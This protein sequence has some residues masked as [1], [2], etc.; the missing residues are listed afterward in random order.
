MGRISAEGR[1]EVMPRREKHDGAAGCARMARLLAGDAQPAWQFDV[2]GEAAMMDSSAA[3]LA[4][5]ALICEKPVEGLK[6]KLVILEF[7]Y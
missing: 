5:E 2:T 7:F 3:K 6:P 4:T 1:G